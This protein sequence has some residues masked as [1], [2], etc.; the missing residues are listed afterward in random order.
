MRLPEMF[1]LNAQAVY[2]IDYFN[3]K[4]NDIHQNP[5]NAEFVNRAED[6]RFS[7][8]RDS[9]GGNGFLEITVV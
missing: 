7:S 8:A 2:L 4:L 5:V 3:K 6:Y 9:T 1:I